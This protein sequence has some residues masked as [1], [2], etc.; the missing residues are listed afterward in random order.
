MAKVN[1]KEDMKNKEV[2]QEPKE[3][4]FSQLLPQSK[5]T[6]SK[7]TIEGDKSIYEVYEG[8]VEDILK[9][10]KELEV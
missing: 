1:I 2:T 5:V 6:Y 10:I 4:D 8:T 7:D 3:P 9:L